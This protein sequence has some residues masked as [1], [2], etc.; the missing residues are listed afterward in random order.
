MLEDWRKKG[1]TSPTSKTTIYPKPD[2]VQI[3]LD[4]FNDD[5]SGR[6]FRGGELRWFRLRGLS[7]SVKESATE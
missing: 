4:T 6:S 2:S 1:A 3:L 5:R 7:R